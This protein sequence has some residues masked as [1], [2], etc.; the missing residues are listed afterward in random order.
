MGAIEQKNTDILEIKKT[1][2]LGFN[3]LAATLTLRPIESLAPA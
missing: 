2:T 1:S 3:Q